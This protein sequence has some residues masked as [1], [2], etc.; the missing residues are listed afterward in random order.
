MNT[1]LRKVDECNISMK[2]IKEASV[3]LKEGG[4]VAFPTETV[5]GLGANALNKKASAKIYEAK[6][7]PSDNPLIVHIAELVA[8]DKIVTVVPEKARML[9]EKFWPGPLTMIFNKKDIVPLETTGGLNTVAVRMPNHKLA[10]SL[11]KESGGYIAAPSANTSGRPSPTKASHVAEDMNGKI[12]MILDGGMVGIGIES[13][14][15]DVSNDNP[16]IL[17]PGYIT[18]EM[19]EEVIGEVYVDQTILAEGDISQR[20]KAPGMKY[21]HYAPKG[22]LTIVEGD[23]NV[24]VERILKLAEEKIAANYQVGIIATDETFGRYSIG[25]VK[26]IGKRSEEQSISH[27]LYNVL[28]EFDD[29]NVDFIYSESFSDGK[30]GVAIMNRLLKAAGHKIIHI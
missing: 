23:E 28:R 22:D 18:K 1:I 15:V 4:L 29:I 19:I 8:L 7:R 24:V 30:L 12:D 3:I 9:A 13:T 20:P 2:F 10:L 11:I 26:S 6:G 25:Q 14:I 16:M 27:N 5:Y 21:K 17:R